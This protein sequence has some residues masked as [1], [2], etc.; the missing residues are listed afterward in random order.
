MLNRRLLL[1]FLLIVSGVA[2]Q[3]PAEEPFLGRST[4]EWNKQ[5][6]SSEGQARVH[7]AW[8]IAQLAGT[9]SGESNLIALDKLL[10]DSDPTVRYW[11]VMGLQFYGLKLANGNTAQ[12]KSIIDRLQPLLDDKSV[13]P[14]IAAA[15]T[16]GLLGKPEAALSV[17]VAAMDDPLDAVRIQAVGA[18][19]KLGPAARPAVATLQ[20]ATSDASEYVKRI[21]ERS[22]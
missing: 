1:Y 14:R 6:A 3:L 19:E 4:E 2:A 8:A 16:V 22:L 15:E 18:L 12:M 7:A 21:S 13:A 20:K 5:F 9:A 17:L 10:H 11:G